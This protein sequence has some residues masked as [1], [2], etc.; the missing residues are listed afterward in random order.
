MFV[1]FFESA[2]R[3]GWHGWRGGKRRNSKDGTH[4]TLE[5]FERGLESV[6][7]WLR[8]TTFTLEQ[9]EEKLKDENIFCRMLFAIRADQ[10]SLT[11]A[12][13]ERGLTDESEWVRKAFA[14]RMDF[15]P[16]EVQFKR[17]LADSDPN[18]RRVF[19]ENKARWEMQKLNQRHTDVVVLKQNLDA[20]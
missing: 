19:Q 13:I 6:G 8:G 16:D 12:Q 15:M 1:R 10:K 2:K 18:I 9:I 11:L 14:E 5:D 7:Q 20:L 4:M 17:G 3:H